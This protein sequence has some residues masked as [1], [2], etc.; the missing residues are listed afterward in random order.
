M[1]IRKKALTIGKADE[2]TII[3]I[4]AMSA[5]FQE[6]HKRK[7]FSTKQ[8]NYASKI[9]NESQKILSNE[10]LKDTP[11]QSFSEVFSKFCQEYS[12]KKQTQLVEMVEHFFASAERS[13]QHL[14]VKTKNGL[15]R[16]KLPVWK[17]LPT[18]IRYTI[19]TLSFRFKTEHMYSFSLNMGRELN[20][21]ITVNNPSDW[22]DR[23]AK[24][25]NY[26]LGKTT[27]KDLK[28][29]F[30]IEYSDTEDI[31]YHLHG[32]IAWNDE[33]KATVRQA[34]KRAVGEWETEKQFQLKLKLNWRTLRIAII[35]SY[36]ALKFPYGLYANHLVKRE[37]RMYYNEIRDGV[38]ATL[39]D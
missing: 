31:G 19:Y 39:A 38:K 12:P 2:K 25:I 23:I 17:S 11:T 4:H 15:V 1:D 9:H 32:F 10:E 13:V 34:M 30:S 18:V 27:C 36:Y 7:S 35:Q 16:C 8:N 22:M 26:H 28:L 5:G 37:A 21:Q 33:K 20:S 29:W 14:V 3:K 6:K 24:R